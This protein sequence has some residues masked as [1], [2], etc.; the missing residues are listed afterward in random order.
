MNM[1][2]PAQGAGA[3]L[4]V[5]DCSSQSFASIF[6]S[7]LHGVGFCMCHDCQT[8]AQLYKSH[9]GQDRRLPG[10]SGCSLPT[11]CRYVAGTVKIVPI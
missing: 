7:L 10:L 5:T 2:A 8:P 9:A 11:H 6:G 4:A 1:A 3:Y